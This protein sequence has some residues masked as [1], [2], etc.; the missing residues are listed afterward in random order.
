M[1]TFLAAM[2][3]MLAVTAIPGEAAA[4][5]RFQ[6][7]RGEI[8][9]VREDYAHDGRRDYRG[10]RRAY[11]YEDVIPERR[12][13]RRLIRKG[14]VSVEDIYLRRDRYIVEAIRPNGA[15]VRL[16]IDAYSGEILVRERIGWVRDGGRRGPGRGWSRSPDIEFDFGGGTFELYSR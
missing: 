1:K 4:G 12:I 8:V 7:G 5:Q 2:S 11:R 16:A 9:V 3:A 6:D 14:F 15:L 10:G 13:V